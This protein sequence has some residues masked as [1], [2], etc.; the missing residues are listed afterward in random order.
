MLSIPIRLRLDEVQ[1]CA[2]WVRWKQIQ[3]ANAHF[4]GAIPNADIF[5][6]GW[7]LRKLCSGGVSVGG[8]CCQ[9]AQIESL[10]SG[11]V[12]I[13]S[14]HRTG[15][16]AVFLPL[17]LTVEMVG[18]QIAKVVAKLVIADTRRT[19]RARTPSGSDVCQNKSRPRVYSQGVGGA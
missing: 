6:P 19:A 10:R 12:A 1:D 9:V 8:V 3:T 4:A 17:P 7:L 13:P 15:A 5:I 11:E 14:P 2:V 18:V 16:I